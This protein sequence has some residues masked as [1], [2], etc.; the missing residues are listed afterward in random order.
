MART[1]RPISWIKAARKAFEAFPEAVQVEALRALTIAAEG[2]KSDIAK[3]MQGLG[4]GIMEIALRHRG[5]AWRM[6]Y[7]VQIGTD[8]WVIHAFQKKSKTG[9]ATPKQEIDLT[10][11]QLLQ[12]VVQA[13]NVAGVEG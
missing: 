2:Q 10:E 7:A 12:L 6:V 5:D 11:K 13:R 1:T 3:P 4:S 8:I 9:I